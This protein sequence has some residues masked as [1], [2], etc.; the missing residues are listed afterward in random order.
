MAPTLEDVDP[1]TCLPA[2]YRWLREENFQD[3]CELYGLSIRGREN[4]DKE[5]GWVYEPDR[6]VALLNSFW[7][8]VKHG[9][10]GHSV[11]SDSGHFAWAAE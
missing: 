4:P 1:Y 6:Q 11:W 9:V 8:I 10:D 7:N 3:V 2:P 5:H